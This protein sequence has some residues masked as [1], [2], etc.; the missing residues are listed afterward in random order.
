MNLI[1]AAELAETPSESWAFREL[2]F[3]SKY[4]LNLSVLIEVNQSIKDSYYFY[5]KNLG[6]LDFIEELIT[7]LEK[8]DG[9]Y[10]GNEP[11]RN[12]II[13]TDRICDTNKKN[14][15]YKICQL[16]GS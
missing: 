10:V 11:R 12:S 5:L 13:K 9:I 7:E 1:I 16:K 14:I 15:W 8:E 3:D 4:K 2:T 6:L